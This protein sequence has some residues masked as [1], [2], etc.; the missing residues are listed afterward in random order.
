MDWAVRRFARHPYVLLSWSDQLLAQPW[1]TTDA[2][3]AEVLGSIRV[4]WPEVETEK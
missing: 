2:E 1:A 4:F 3:Q